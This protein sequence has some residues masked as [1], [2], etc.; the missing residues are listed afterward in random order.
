MH[1]VQHIVHEGQGSIHSYY[2]LREALNVLA[3]GDITYE[4]NLVPQQLH[5]SR[6]P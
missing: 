3:L 4:F 5:V 2:D 1:L 6:V